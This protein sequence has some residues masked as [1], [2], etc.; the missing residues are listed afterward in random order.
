MHYDFLFI[1][2]GLMKGFCVIGARS[3]QRFPGFEEIFCIGHSA[4]VRSCVCSNLIINVNK[5]MKVCT[6]F[7]IEFVTSVRTPAKRCWEEEIVKRF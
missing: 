3:Q 5:F 2:L 1:R 4:F 7:G 6:K